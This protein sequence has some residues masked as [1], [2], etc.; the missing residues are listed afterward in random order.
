MMQSSPGRIK[1]ARDFLA[2]SVSLS[3]LRE[4]DEAGFL[5]YLNQKTDA[6]SLELPRPDDG[7]PNWG[8]ARKVLNIFLRLCAMNKDLN[9]A[10]SLDA[11]EPHLEVPLDRQV[12]AKID[13]QT[14]SKFAKGFKIR[15]STK[16]VSAD[17]QAVA[18]RIAGARG[19][20]RYELDVLFWNVGELAR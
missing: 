2:G 11:A 4:L 12:V 20:H 1:R 13:K 6:L 9:P 5:D 3:M 10:F 15:N 7:A 17:I 8:A 14:G 18:T 16:D 19:V